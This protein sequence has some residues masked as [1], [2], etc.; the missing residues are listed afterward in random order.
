MYGPVS[1]PG[2][3][4]DTREIRI[5]RLIRDNDLSDPELARRLKKLIRDGDGNRSVSLVR[6]D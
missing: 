3:F 4:M 6:A 1:L 2:D 5:R